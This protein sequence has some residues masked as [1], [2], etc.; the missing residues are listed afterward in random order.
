MSCYNSPRTIIFPPGG[1]SN[2]HLNINDSMKTVKNTRS[3]GGLFAAM[4]QL[5]WEKDIDLASTIQTPTDSLTITGRQRTTVAMTCPVSTADSSSVLQEIHLNAVVTDHD[6]MLSVP[7]PAFQRTSRLEEI[8]NKV[9]L[10]NSGFE[11]QSR[12][13]DNRL[14]TEEIGHIPGA[15][16][17]SAESLRNSRAPYQT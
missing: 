2:A 13:I 1:V 11:S 9:E 14:A 12:N 16:M 10:R 3:S 8:N 6:K 5:A 7:R 17:T 4:S 15:L